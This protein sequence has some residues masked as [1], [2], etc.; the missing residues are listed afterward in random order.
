MS[1]SPNAHEYLREMHIWPLS[2]IAKGLILY[3]IYAMTSKFITPQDSVQDQFNT[4]ATNFKVV[5]F[6]Q[7]CFGIKKNVRKV[8]CAKSA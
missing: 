4:K 2:V 6:S 1:A 8:E 3:Q 5:A 7:I